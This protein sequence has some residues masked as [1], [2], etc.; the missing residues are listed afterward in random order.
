MRQAGRLEAGRLEAGRLAGCQLWE[1][2]LKKTGF[3]SLLLHLP[4]SYLA[5]PPVEPP[6]LKGCW[7]RPLTDWG[8]LVLHL[9][10]G[11]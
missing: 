2:P 7:A 8:L 4:V 6:G 9:S 3:P 11:P 10:K 1:V 5:P